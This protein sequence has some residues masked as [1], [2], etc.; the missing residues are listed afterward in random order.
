[1]VEATGAPIAEYFAALD[2]PRIE[3]TKRHK[4]L[5]I[6]TIAICGTICGADNWV[7][8]ELFGN[9]KEEWFKS[10]LELPNGIPS[11]DTFGD[12]F[13][14]LDPE[15]FQR[16][17]I[18]WVQAV[19]QLTQGEVVA[20]DG[21]TVRRSYDRT[22]GK[23]AIHM[24]NVWASSNGLALGQ[25]KVEEKSNEITAIPKLLQLLELTGCIVTIDA[26]G[27]QKEIARGIVEAQA[28]YLLAVKENQGQLYEDVRDLF[29]GAEEFDFQGVPYDFARTLHK[30]HGRIETRRCWV[31][32]DPDCLDYLQTRQQWAKLNAVVK[33]TAQRER[34]PLRPLSNPATTSAVWPGKPRPCW[35]PPADIG[36]SKTACTGPW[37]LPFEKITAVSVR[38]MVLRTWLSCAR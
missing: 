25:T 13:A 28:D 37:T 9:C 3:R 17:F 36:V 7:D 12:V 15:Q 33:V 4:L 35:R 31:I 19:A 30:N 21:K 8:I 2:D 20:I 10:F 16:C 34:R 11:H 22:R 1:M 29:E 32:T 14:R 23:Q 27:C 18:E 38:I 5:D 6:V 26:M 24:V